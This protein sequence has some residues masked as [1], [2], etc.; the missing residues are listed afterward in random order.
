MPSLSRPTIAVTGASGQLG[1]RVVELLIEADP[2][3]IVAITRTPA[4]LEEFAARGVE[5]REGDF[6]KPDE[7]AAAFAGVD[8]LLIVSTDTV[9]RPGGR[10]TQHAPAVKAAVAAGVRHV[11]YTS[12]P[13]ATPTGHDSIL[14]DHYWTEVALA[15]SKLSWTILRNNIYAEMLLMSLPQAVA[16]GQLY[17]ATGKGGR[18]YV[19]R[20]DC[21]R[22]AVAALVSGFDGRRILDIT[23]PAPVTQDE[24]AAIASE[25]AGKPVEHIALSAEDLVKG[26]VAAGMPANVAELF[27]DLDVSAAR[28]YQAIVTPAVKDLT[29]REPTSVREFLT[30]NREALLKAA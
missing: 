5:I 26:M 27:V 23:G 28:G 4:K 6:D 10:V 9:G 21:A 1:R 7:L 19:T 12:G 24:V 8:R 2:G 22:A 29:G 11:I 30:A 20:E 3:R 13:G 18:N 17:S 14:N 25:L 16:S 15:E